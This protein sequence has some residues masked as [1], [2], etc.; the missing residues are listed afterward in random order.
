[1]VPPIQ[2]KSELSAPPRALP[3]QQVTVQS[4]I[5]IDPEAAAAVLGPGATPEP[6]AAS[7]PD[8]EGEENI[9]EVMK[10]HMRRKQEEAD[11]KWAADKAQKAQQQRGR[12]GPI[13]PEVQ[14][15][16][17]TRKADDLTD[18][19]DVTAA[20][21]EYLAA[22]ARMLESILGPCLRVSALTAA[23]PEATLQIHKTQQGFTNDLAKGKIEA[24]LRAVTD[25]PLRIT[26][27]FVDPPKNPNA[28][29]PGA[30]AAPPAQTAQRVPPE[31][32]EA[33]KKQ[34]LIQELMKRFDASVTQI[35]L[36]GSGDE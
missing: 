14:R 31:V 5:V 23:P 29:V 8:D 4:H 22:N 34:P 3:A 2:K 1:M 24:A 26:Y 27:E 25:L 21:R 15:P 7:S 33:V 32:T 36:L 18:M 11:A 19:G 10:Q 30:P 28:P 20:L 16:A 13:K 17:E 12:P 35:E 6:A 9:Y